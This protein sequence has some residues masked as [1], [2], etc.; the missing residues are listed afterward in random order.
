MQHRAA[1]MP[2]LQ[3][4]ASRQRRAPA[5]RYHGEAAVDP[6]PCYI[7]P[8]ISPPT[9]SPEEALPPSS[10]AP[11]CSSLSCGGT[12]QPLSCSSCVWCARSSRLCE[13]VIVVT[14]L[15]A[16]L[17]THTHMQHMHGE[18][19]GSAEAWARVRALGFGRCPTARR[20]RCAH[21]AKSLASK[22]GP[23]L[24]YYLRL[25]TATT[26]CL[27]GEELRLECGLEVGGRLIEHN[28][29][30]PLHVEARRR[31]TLLLAA[32][33]P[34]ASA[35]GSQRGRRGG[36]VSEA[37][38]PEGL[39]HARAAAR[40]GGG[41][42]RGGRGGVEEELGERGLGRRVRSLRHEE[43]TRRGWKRDDGAL[44]R[45]PHARQ[46]TEQG[47]LARAVWPPGEGE[48]ERGAGVGE[49]AGVGGCGGSSS[50]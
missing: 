16:H 23:T 40:G 7:S 15:L 6:T 36:E 22:A 37:G 48:G 41:V 32:R 20:R 24:T 3:P 10:S 19:S 31:E 30:G 33:E 9:T 35:R 28:E 8:P 12:P 11:W 17:V 29:A 14:P 25:T 46:H 27:P 26:C 18:G 50:S 39:E 43:D 44:C 47:G 4:T 45:R 34:R 42:G 13:I 1:H 49:W 38:P 2:A 21:Q 5:Q